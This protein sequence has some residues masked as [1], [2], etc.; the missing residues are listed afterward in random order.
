MHRFSMYADLQELYKKYLIG[1]LGGSQQTPQIPPCES[2]FCDNFET[3][4]FTSN[5]FINEYQE[6]FEIEWFTNNN[7]ILQGNEDFE[8]SDWDEQE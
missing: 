1:E 2:T 6:T 4:W 7:Y 8:S 5:N 3:E